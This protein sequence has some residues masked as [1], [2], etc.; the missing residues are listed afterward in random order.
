MRGQDK[1]FF[2]FNIALAVR[3][4][5]NIP[6]RDDYKKSVNLFPSFLQEDSVNVADE[7]EDLVFC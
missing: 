3:E 6:I 2:R 7:M 4:R 5:V 1:S